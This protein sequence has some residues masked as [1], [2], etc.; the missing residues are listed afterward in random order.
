MLSHFNLVQ[1]FA[2]LRTFTCQAPLTVEFSRQEYWNGLPCPTPGDLP[3]PVTEPMSLMS[4]ELA[5]GFFTTGTT[6]E[7]K[8][9]VVN[10]S[11]EDRWEEMISF[12]KIQSSI[13]EIEN[14]LV[15]LR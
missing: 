6:W 5:G 14:N 3:N 12:K 10:A 1:L 15:L 11:A 13:I 8:E 7:A 2:T 9:W 4:L